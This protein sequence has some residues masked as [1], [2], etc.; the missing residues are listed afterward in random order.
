MG[1]NN[2]T[3]TA[4]CYENE[5]VNFNHFEILRAIGKGSFGK[6]CIVQ[7]N[8]TKKMYAM[9]YMNKQKCVERNEVRNVFKELQIMQGLEHP[10]LVN[11]WVLCC[12]CC[13]AGAAVLVLVL[14]L[15]CCGAVLGCW[16][17]ALEKENQVTEWCDITEPGLRKNL[18]ACDVA[19]EGDYLEPRFP[20][21]LLR[22]I[23]LK[24]IKPDN[25]MLDEEG[26]ARICDFGLVAENITG[27]VLAQGSTGTTTHMAPEVAAE[28]R[29]G[30]SADWWSLGVT[31]HQMLTGH[32]PIYI[33]LPGNRCSCS[34]QLRFPPHLSKESK[35]VLSK[36]LE[37]SPRLRLG[38][39]SNIRLHP[40][41]GAI[42]WRDLEA[43]A[44]PPPYKPRRG[45]AESPLWNVRKKHF[46]F[47]EPMKYHTFSGD[48]W[49]IPNLSFTSSIL[50]DYC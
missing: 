15:G 27:G 34:K 16:C 13:G 39:R 14:V 49:V 6:V 2:S 30:A 31:L 8:D 36:L 32:L 35:D 26:H 33:K 4:V 50:R 29:Y 17:Y 24:D 19:K 18:Y 40:F 41:F 7:K 23:I 3:K 37:E 9:K 45:P 20:L 10:F 43:K 5:E 48:S 1:A 38:V 47:M 25:I 22:P 12:W 42:N 11:L 46:S 44:I 21:R 28:R